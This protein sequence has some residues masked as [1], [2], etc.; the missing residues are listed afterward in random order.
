VLAYLLALSCLFVLTA[1]SPKALESPA[2]VPSAET[3]QSSSQTSEIAA[4]LVAMPPPAPTPVYLALLQP[5]PGS[6]LTKAQF[7]KVIPIEELGFYELHG[8][9]GRVAE[10]AGMRSSICFHLDAKYLVEPGD[11]LVTDTDI[12][13]RIELLVNGIILDERAETNYAVVI[14]PGPVINYF[15][16]D[17]DDTNWRGGDSISETKAQPRRHLWAS[18]FGLG[19]GIVTLWR[20]IRVSI[21]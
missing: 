16:P 14:E 9:P 18:I 15:D 7:E 5:A 4:T 2:A 20:L 17:S 19:F 1:C 11:A 3:P 8:Q 21:R 6:I 12:L 10:M 13:S